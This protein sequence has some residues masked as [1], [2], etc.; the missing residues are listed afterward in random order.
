MLDIN[1]NVQTLD[2]V[3]Q[4]KTVKVLVV[5]EENEDYTFIQTLINESLYNQ[6]YKI[7]WIDNY[8]A[9][10]NAMLKKHH[11][12]YLVDYKLGNYSGLALLHE[13][14]CSNCTDPIIMLSSKADVHVDRE[15]LRIGATSYLV[16]ENIDGHTLERSMRYAI[17]QSGVWKSLKK[18]ENKFRV[19]FERSKYPILITDASGKIHDANPATVKF[20]GLP[21]QKL[22][23]TNDHSFYSAKGDRDRFVQ[24]MEDNG[25]VND[26]E[27]TLM[28]PNGQTKFCSISSF[29]QISQHATS[30]LYYSIIND[31]TAKKEYESVIAEKMAISEHIVK[32]LAAEIQNPLSNVNMALLELTTNLNG[33][34][35]SL[36]VYLDIVKEN[37]DRIDQLTKNLF[38]PVDA[39]L[40]SKA[41]IK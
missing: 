31:L 2:S 5:A 19:L 35:E 24:A 27:Q 22:L 32:N 36:K 25:S 10:I 13:A 21:L 38:L 28:L 16:K 33:K 40:N 41:G 11:D 7:E 18:N 34:N 3:E 12:L 39:S 20:F 1:Q 17:E 8:A 6:H 30:I 14:I 4:Q 26:M 23:A 9:A 29:V 37:F 15:A